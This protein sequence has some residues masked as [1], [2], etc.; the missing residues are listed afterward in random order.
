MEAA[1]GADRRALADDAAGADDDALADARAALDDAARPRR[2]RSRA[3]LRVR[4][5]DRRGVHARATG[6]GGL[7]S[8]TTRAK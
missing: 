1:V 5:D 4:R 8:A 6:A 3:T 2:S 7:K